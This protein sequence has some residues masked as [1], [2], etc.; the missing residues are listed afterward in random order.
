M[1]TMPAWSYSSLNDFLNCPRSYQLKRVTK[2]CKSEGSEAMTY[3]NAVHKYLE[4]R[5]RLQDPLPKELDW[6]EPHIVTMERSG[7]DLLAEQSVGITEAL[8]PCGYWDKKVWARG[9]LDLSIRYSYP[10]QSVIIDYKTG[11]RK[12]DADQL[13]LFAGFEFALNPGVEQI[14]TGYIW[15]KDRKIDKEVFFPQDKARIWG[16]F[17]PKVERLAQAYEKDVW[18]CKPSGLCPWCPAKMSQCQYSTK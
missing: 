17:L 16:H 1:T 9:K 4:D 3:G 8:E 2:E 12:V 15:L 11:K 14:K 18:P 7:G 10:I 6:I 13:M 5:V